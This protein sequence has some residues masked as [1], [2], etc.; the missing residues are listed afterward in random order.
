MGAIDKVTQAKREAWKFKVTQPDANTIYVAKAKLGT[1]EATAKWQCCKILVV[2][3]D[4]TV[5]WADGNEEFDNAA[6]NLAGL[7]YS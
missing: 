3:A 5:T 6:T 7:S 2:G 4:T 1:A